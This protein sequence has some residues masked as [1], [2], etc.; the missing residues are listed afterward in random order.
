MNYTNISISVPPIAFNQSTSTGGVIF[1]SYTT[2]ILFPLALPEGTLANETSDRV[3]SPVI[4]ATVSTTDDSP[5]RNLPDS[6]QIELFSFRI[7]E[8]PETMGFQVGE[9]KNYVSDLLT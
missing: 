3:D 9:S 2:P 1:S 8:F 4:S 5:V 7:Q 6:V